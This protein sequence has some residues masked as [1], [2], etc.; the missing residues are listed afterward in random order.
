M[1]RWELEVSLLLSGIGLGVLL[2]LAWGVSLCL[3]G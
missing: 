2:G 3:G 1:S